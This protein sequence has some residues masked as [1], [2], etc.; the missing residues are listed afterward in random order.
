ME[1]ELQQCKHQENKKLKKEILQ[2]D[3]KL[4]LRLSIVTYHTL[5]HQINIAVKS[6]LKTINKRHAKKLANFYNRRNKTERQEPKRVPKNVAHN[7]SSYRYRI[8]Y[9][10]LYLMVWVIKFLYGT[11]EIILQVNLSIFVK[12]FVMS[13]HIYLKFKLGR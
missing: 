12:V 1:N 6:R 8:L 13:I 10:L 3:K 4:R 5:L 7:F 2:L 9:W 11:I